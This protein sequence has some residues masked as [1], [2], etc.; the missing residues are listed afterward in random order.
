M[1]APPVRIP[2]QHVVRDLV[3]LALTLALWTWDARLRT[4]PTSALS[5]AVAL[6][7]GFMTALCGY[8][9]HEWGHL[10]GAWTGGSVVHLPESAA[11][12]FLFRFDSDRNTREQFLRMSWGGFL[13]SGVSI[14]LLLLVLPLDA[15][16]GRVAFGLV[17]AGVAATLILEVPPFRR[18]ARGAAIPTGAAYRSAA[19]EG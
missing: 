16:S 4:E 3:L 6:T 9:V 1:Q 8:L 10:V 7:T 19:D 5:I 17:A 11:S 12:T 14:V 18:V 2:T 15:W 13:A